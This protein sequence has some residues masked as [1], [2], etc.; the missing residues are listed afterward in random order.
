MIAALLPWWR[1]RTLSE[2]RLLLVAGLLLFVGVIPALAY[3]SAVSYRREAAADLARAERTAVL[4][5]QVKG[6]AAATLP[7]N[8]GSLRGLILAAA[9]ASQLPAPAIEPIG[10]DRLRV[11]FP[12]APSQ[13]VFAWLSVMAQ[14]GA[15]VVKSTMVRAGQGGLVTAEFEVAQAT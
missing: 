14:H 2:R 11:A 1:A 13:A 7:Q 12:A 8:D 3:Q 10:T 5:V 6:A 15:L 4:L 9:T